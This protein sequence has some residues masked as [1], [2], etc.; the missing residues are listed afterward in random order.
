MTEPADSTFC[1]RQAE[2]FKRLSQSLPDQSS[3]K[4]FAVLAEGWMELASKI[5]QNQLLLDELD[6]IARQRV[7][8]LN[9]SE[10]CDP[11]IGPA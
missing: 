9:S 1:R 11:R 6:A 2:D 3:R 5:D 4:D 10:V 8:N 7:E